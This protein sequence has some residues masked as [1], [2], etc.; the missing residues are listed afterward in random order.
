[1]KI[2]KFILEIIKSNPGKLIFLLLM[3]SSLGIIHHYWNIQYTDCGQ[4]YSE[5]Q[6]SGKWY[7]SVLAKGEHDPKIISFD[8]KQAFKDN[9]MVWQET[10]PALIISWITFVI[11]LIIFLVVSSTEDGWKFTDTWRYLS[12]K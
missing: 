8:N 10:H 3:F 1:M 5:F 11:L 7:Y 9:Y 6:Q 4:V 2:I 12:I